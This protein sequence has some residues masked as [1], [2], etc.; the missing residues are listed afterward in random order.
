MTAAAQQ[1]VLDLSKKSKYNTR[2]IIQKS[3][4]KSTQ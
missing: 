3:I 4:F 1:F 2:G